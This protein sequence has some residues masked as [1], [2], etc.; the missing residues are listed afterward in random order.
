MCGWE[1]NRCISGLVLVLW[2]RLVMNDLWLC[3][4]LMMLCL[5]SVCR[6]LCR[7]ECE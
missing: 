1:L 5:C 7:V 2:L 4:V 3:L 6:F